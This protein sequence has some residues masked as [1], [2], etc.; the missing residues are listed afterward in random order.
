MSEFSPV[1]VIE[2]AVP[3]AR[4]PKFVHVPVSAVLYSTRVSVRLF[5]LFDQLRSTEFTVGLLAV[6]PE[7]GAT[8]VETAKTVVVGADEML[9]FTVEMRK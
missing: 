6:R 5:V 9:P 4:V 2:F 8:S 3:I 1:T 7:G